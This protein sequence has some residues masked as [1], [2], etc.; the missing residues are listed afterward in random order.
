MRRCRSCRKRRNILELTHIREPSTH[1]Y[2][3]VCSDIANIF[4][5]VA[6]WYS[7]SC[8]IRYTTEEALRCAKFY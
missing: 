5:N 7:D 6:N 2:C 1:G 8:Y 3:G 4:D